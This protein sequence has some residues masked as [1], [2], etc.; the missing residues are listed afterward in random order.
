LDVGASVGQT[1]F[2]LRAGG[3]RGRIVSFEPQTEAFRELARVAGNDDAWE[4]RKVAIGD[5]RSNVQV[6]ISSNS[7]SSSLLPMSER[8]RRASPGSA[9]ADSEEVQLFRLDDLRAELVR[10]DDR[11]YL[12]LDVQGYEA[13]AI[14]G[15]AETLRQTVVVEAEVSLVEL[16]AGQALM[17]DFV[18]LMRGHN[19][20]PLHLA[21][22]FRDPATGELLQLNVWFARKSDV[23]TAADVSVA[24][25]LSLMADQ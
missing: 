7:W 12:K 22:E 5:R 20:F 24:T 14:A 25:G 23:D 13:Q 11:L 15:A 18:T 19:F 17:S 1:G 8:H 10:K 4:C 2:A 21:P 16:Y 3:Y 6:N 9:Y